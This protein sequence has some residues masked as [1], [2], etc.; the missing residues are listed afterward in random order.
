MGILQVG[1][2]RET[3][4]FISSFVFLGLYFA[5][6][7][8]GGNENTKIDRGTGSDASVEAQV[9]RNENGTGI[10]LGSSLDLNSRILES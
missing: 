10:G 7:C 8:Q 2:E 9:T 6:T 4:Q 1:S 3:S 5:N